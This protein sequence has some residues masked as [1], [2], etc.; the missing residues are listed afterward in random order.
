ML[1]MYE[2]LKPLLP[3]SIQDMALFQYAEVQIEITRLLS[4]REIMNVEK[5]SSKVLLKMLTG[6]KVKHIVTPNEEVVRIYKRRKLRTT[7]TFRHDVSGRYGVNT[8]TIVNR[9]PKP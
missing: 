4:D 7:M 6:I 9:A 3:K 1:K 2:N 8:R 5:F